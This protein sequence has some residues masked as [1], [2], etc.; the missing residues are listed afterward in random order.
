MY[1]RT[2]QYSGQGF[3]LF[4]SCRSNILLGRLYVTKTQFQ[5]FEDVLGGKGWWKR[6]MKWFFGYLGAWGK[7]WTWRGVCALHWWHSYLSYSENAV[8]PQV[9]GVQFLQVG[10]WPWKLRYWNLSCTELGWFCILS[11]PGAAVI[12]YWLP[13]WET[14]SEVWIV[15]NI[16]KLT[17]LSS[18][19]YMAP[20]KLPSILGG[21]FWPS[22]RC[23]SS[24]RGRERTARCRSLLLW[25][26]SEWMETEI[27]RV[28]L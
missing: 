26:F 11:I 22:Q 10:L 7:H 18:C 19:A 4:T 24:K 3:L 21:S 17:I 27:H 25:C 5:M 1:T 9:V 28:P 6:W 23:C 12:L 2:S 13:E 20:K 8:S 14:L 16:G 15:Q